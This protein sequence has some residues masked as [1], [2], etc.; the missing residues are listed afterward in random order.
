MPVADDIETIRV[1][2]LN[3]SNRVVIGDDSLLDKA[4]RPTVVVYCREDVRS[5][6]A[7]RSF[8]CFLRNAANAIFHG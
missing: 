4:K 2:D 8:V 5:L 6:P 1:E 7:K 3:P